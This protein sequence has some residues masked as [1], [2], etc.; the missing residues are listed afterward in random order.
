M[1]KTGFGF[2]RLPKLNPEDDNSVDFEAVSTLVDRF[3]A[4]GGSYF[5]TAYTYLGGNSERAIRECVVNRYPREKVQIADKLPSWMLKCPEDCARFFEEQLDRCGV[6]YFDVYLLHGLDAENYALCEKFGAF[7]FLE[8]LRRNAKLRKTGFSYHDSPEL[9]NAILDAH[10]EL[11]YV[12]LQINYLDWES[13]SIQARKCYEVAV[14]HGKQVLVME[15]VKGGSLANPPES[16]K[17][18]LASLNPAASPASW[19]IRFAQNLPAVEIVLSGMNALEQIEDN[20]LEHLPLSS[21]EL[22]TLE[23]AA[24]II[25]SNTAVACSSCAYCVE[26]C[27]QRIPIPKLFSLFN[28]YS[29]SPGELWKMEYMY[30]DLTASRGK[31][32]DCQRCGACEAHCPQK[33]GIIDSLSKVAEVFEGKKRT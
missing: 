29:C 30:A 22:H 1:N 31:A 5:D 11:D 20:M 16:V 25:R 18:L 2:L 4:L 19:A 17:E 10:P 9:L 8:E 24:E 6:N 15:P 33:L 28:E 3:V 27:P 26:G 13:V 32:S 7:A 14:H 12:Q 21:I 23:K